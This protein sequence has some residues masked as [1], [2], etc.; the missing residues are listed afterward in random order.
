MSE[1]QDRLRKYKAYVSSLESM[2][3]GRVSSSVLSGAREELFSAELAADREWE[4]EKREDRE[5][6]RLLDKKEEAIKEV[7]ELRRL[8]EMSKSD[9][10]EYG[11]KFCKKNE[12]RYEPSDWYWG[13]FWD[14]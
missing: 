12:L 7:R 1:Q 3:A 14:R 10:L 4:E 8:G 2:G 13:D 11:E 5:R 9:M 6:W